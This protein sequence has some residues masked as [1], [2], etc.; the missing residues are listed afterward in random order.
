M[1]VTPHRRLEIMTRQA[2]Q[3]NG[4]SPFEAIRHTNDAGGDYWSARELGTLLGYTEYGKF[5]G[6][7]ARAEQVCEGSGQAVSDHFAHVSD[8]VDIG[9]GAHRKPE[10]T[11]KSK[12]ST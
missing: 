4:Q 5:K 10:R 8:M 1:L 6:A 7:I 2:K 9:S 12:M 11:A 3:A